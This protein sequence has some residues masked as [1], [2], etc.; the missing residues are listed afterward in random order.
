MRILDLGC[1]TG[2]ASESFLRAISEVERAGLSGACV[3]PDPA[4]LEIARSKLSA[5]PGVALEFVPGSAERIP[6][7]DASSDVVLVGS[8]F[9]WFQT[10]RAV[11]EITR[12]S[13]P[14][15]RALLFEYQFPKAIDRPELN[16]WIRREFNENWRAPNQV[17]RGSLKEISRPWRTHPAWRERPAPRVEMALPLSGFGFYGH[18]LSQSRYL[19]FE[20]GLSPE[21]R[22]R[23]R[24]NLLRRIMASY[25]TDLEL[26]FDFYFQAFE[27]ERR[28]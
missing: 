27:L 4:M 28:P 2:A 26:R 1:G 15:A 25:G 6:R 22:L 10:T 14:G 8:A 13:A 5:F 9:H 12:V 20:A 7:D 3:D 23:Y 24:E 21:N 16:E 17:P 18:L 11:E 19:H